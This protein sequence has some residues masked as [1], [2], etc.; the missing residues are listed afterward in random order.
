MKK[1]KNVIFFF[2]KKI[3]FEVKEIYLKVLKISNAFKIYNKTSQ[4]I[5]KNVNS[6]EKFTRFTI[7]KSAVI[8]KLILKISSSSLLQDI[9][10]LCKWQTTHQFLIDVYH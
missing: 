7:Y 4:Y 8:E 6:I 10:F 5:S 2:R 1:R 9:A 3:P